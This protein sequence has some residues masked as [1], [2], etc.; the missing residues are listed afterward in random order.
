MTD[1]RPVD[2]FDNQGRKRA[3][4]QEKEKVSDPAT[5]GSSCGVRLH[6]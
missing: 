3:G 4:V 2:M 6:A 1:A 5:G